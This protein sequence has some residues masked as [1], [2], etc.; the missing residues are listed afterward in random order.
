VVAIGDGANDL[1]MMKEAGLGVAW[2]AKA[3]VQ[4]EADIRLNGYTLLNLLHIF[5]F[6][7]EEVKALIQ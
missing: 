2:N 7:A 6:T 4:M 1:L 5:G 3:T